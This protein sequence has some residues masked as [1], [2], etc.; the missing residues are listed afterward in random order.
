MHRAYWSG[1]IPAIL[2]GVIGVLILVAVKYDPP[3]WFQ[4][5]I[6]SLSIIAAAITTIGTYG[7]WSERASQH[8][9]A[10][11]EY[12]KL[13]RK[14]EETLASPPDAEI[15]QKTIK[16][17][18]EKLDAIP[19]EAPPVLKKVWK[20]LPPELTPEAENLGL[21]RTIGSS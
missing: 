10:A 15:M 19:G 7:K 3:A 5:S 16:A 4:I 12:G 9:T 11:A 2:S 17:I 20:Q 14:I 21:R 1:V 18:R 6:G 13:L 8:H